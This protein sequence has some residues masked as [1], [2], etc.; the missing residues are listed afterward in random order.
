V[1]AADDHSS[2][3]AAWRYGNW[4]ILAS[5]LALCCA[6][7][8]Q[9]LGS[10]YIT[11]WD[12][13]IH[14]NVVQNLAEHCCEPRLHRST[15]VA[16]LDRAQGLTDLETA[17]I[18]MSQL[19]LGTDYRDWANNTIW[20]HKPLLPFYLAAATFKLGRGSLWGFRLCGAIFALLNA[21]IIYLVGRK[22][23]TN[24]VGLFALAI[25]G[26]NPYTIQLVHGQA[27]AGFPDLALSCCIST[28]MYLVLYWTRYRSLA[29]LRLLGVAVAIGYL[30]KGELALGPFA[31]LAVV[32]IVAG[33]YRDFPPMLQSIG[34]FAALVIP[35]HLYWLIRQPV[36]MS[37][38]SHMQM[39]HLFKVVEG[40]GG[41]LTSYVAGYAP[42]I[43]TL[44][45]I[46]IAYFSLAWAVVRFKP[47]DTEFVLGIW[48]LVYFVT[49]SFAVSKIENFIF[50][51]LAAFALLIPR[52]LDGLL[53]NRQ[54]D[55]ILALC[56]TTLAMFFVM[57]VG[58]RF[59]YQGSFAL[60]VFIAAFVLFS[61]WKS[62]SE[63][64]AVSALALTAAALLL[65]Y[66]HNDVY[67]NTT[68]AADFAAQATLRETGLALRP[69]VDNNGLI[70][71]H[72]ESVERS[73]L[74]LMYWS[75]VD[76]LDVCREPDPL[77][78]MVSLQNVSG[79]YLITER[80]LPEAPLGKTPIGNLYS[81]KGVPFQ[82]WSQAATADC[83]A[84]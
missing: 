68:K 70:L 2:R 12:E 53:R 32:T 82:D 47:A 42:A 8:L 19:R 56:L 39:L 66:V 58:W 50:P 49:L 60:I 59:I 29:A 16:G 38:E 40:H 62:R 75:A 80:Q 5:L 1:N 3:S 25:F 15:A 81:L 10:P 63:A 74:Y 4:L 76:V 13:A 78:A 46:P 34:I 11:L 28:S 21:A 24:S 79:L 51:A 52:V 33:K 7:Y 43:F 20:L 55:I 37:H 35:E 77:S 18:P 72:G 48:I 23:L 61:R 41:S 83:P 26:L 65:L 9:N 44:P 84:K 14:V 64:L 45:L 71:A 73:Y 27:F 36:V 6:L 30:C 57:R 22:F 54:F 67:D 69:L 17:T 31:G